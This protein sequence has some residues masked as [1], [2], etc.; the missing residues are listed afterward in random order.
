MSRSRDPSY[1]K[2]I[3]GTHRKPSTLEVITLCWETDRLIKEARQFYE[4]D[5]RPTLLDQVWSLLGISLTYV[6]T[7]AFNCLLVSV[8]SGLLAFG[9]VAALKFLVL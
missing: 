4:P 7:V 1:L 5:Y 9:A 2:T 8:L 6:L 3:T